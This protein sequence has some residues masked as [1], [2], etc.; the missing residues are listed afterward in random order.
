MTTYTDLNTS[1]R[2]LLGPGP[3]TVHPRVLRAMAQPLVGHLDP[4]FLALMNEVQELLRYVFQT[5]NEL[6]IPVSGTGSAAMEAALCNFIEPGDVVL[7]GVNGYFGERLC[8]MA[9]RYGA[10]VQRLEKAWGDVFEPE[11]VEAAL[12]RQPAKLVALVHAETSTGALQ[13]MEGMAE[14]VHRY[15]G[16]L[17]IDCVTSLGGVPVEIDAWD[18]DI[19]YSGTQKCLSCPPGLGPLTVGE[20]AREMLRKRK[21]RVAN[22]YLD[23]T[24]IEKYW[25]DARTYHHT[26]PISMNYALREALR[27]VYE[28]GL[29]ARFRRHRRHAEMLW[30][31]LEELGLQ[32]HVPLAH[33]L[34]TLTTPR[35]PAGVDEV[36][37]R[38]R[39]LNEYNIEIAG[40][41]G[42]LA[43][44][45]WRI[46]LMGYSSRQENVTLLLAALRELL[47]R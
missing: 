39:L 35:V 5:G 9:V 10:E 13:P 40:G 46:G 6:T 8:D 21:S 2:I 4:Q 1:A 11:E 41:L 29:E 47:G 20:R 37:V 7:I 22:W 18:V 32:M 31:G 25:G 15:G 3:S 26:A 17:L 38:K 43:G 30:A 36:A 28:E 34:P 14:V 45:V 19:A 27:L 42:V 23:L 16:L 33:R 24:M 12:R 44:K